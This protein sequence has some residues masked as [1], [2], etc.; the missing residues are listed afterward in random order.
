MPT[1][2]P[3]WSM[4]SFLLRT[5]GVNTPAPCSTAPTLASR[6]AAMSE[7]ERPAL[8]EI[9]AAQI[10]NLA[11]TLQPRTLSTYRTTVNSFLGYLQANHPET[12]TFSA[13]RREHVLGWLRSLCER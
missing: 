11:V 12:R 2:R 6:E 5:S 10:A 3:P 1:F 8:K 9:F 13:L 4:F 7:L